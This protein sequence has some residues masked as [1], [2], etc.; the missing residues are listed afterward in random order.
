MGA[1][2]PPDEPPAEGETSR[3]G[4]QGWS[5]G[6]QGAPA[7]SSRRSGEGQEQGRPAGP[8]EPAREEQPQ[9][10]APWLPTTLKQ[11]QPGVKSYT[12]P[13]DP[14][15]LQGEGPCRPGYVKQEEPEDLAQPRA[16]A[17]DNQARGAGGRLGRIPRELVRRLGKCKSPNFPPEV[18]D[19]F[20]P[21]VP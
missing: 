18:Y 2:E 1:S 17:Q 8:S 20:G 10:G 16:E 15:Q 3:P 19:V 11:E 21:F 4:G 7:E 9:F 14:E 12:G 13:T 5:P 6:E